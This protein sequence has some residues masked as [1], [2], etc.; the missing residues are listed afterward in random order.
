VRVPIAC[1]LTADLSANRIEEWRTALRT[2][3]SGVARSAPGRV[4]L[5]IVDGPHHAGRLVD[6]ARREKAC[7]AFF[8]F[9]VE[10][11]SQGVTMVV[12]VPHDAVAVLDDILGLLE[13]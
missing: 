13:A 10:I 4:E 8:T 2:S 9:A 1:T 11:D 12:E 3:I 7:C 5:R 6:L